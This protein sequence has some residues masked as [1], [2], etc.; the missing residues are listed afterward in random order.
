M[1]SP[2][3]KARRA[4]GLV[5]QVAWIAMVRCSSVRRDV[6]MNWWCLAWVP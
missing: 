5:G 1:E 2:D 4:C 6:T 3:E